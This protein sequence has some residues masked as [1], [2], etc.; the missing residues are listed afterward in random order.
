VRDPV[1]RNIS[2]FFES[3]AEFI[4]DFRPESPSG[5]PRVEELI[6]TFLDRYDHD[7]PLLWF[8]H[9]MKPVFGIDVFARAFPKERGYG[10][11]EGPNASLLVIKLEKVKECVEGAMRDF[12]GLEEFVLRSANVAD[13]KGY[14]AVY[15]MFLDAIELPSAY[16]DRMY[17]SQLARHFYTEEE[18]GAFR[19]RW[20]KLPVPVNGPLESTRAKRVES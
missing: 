18:I 9:Q 10:V 17:E 15:R 4:P 11:Y 7:T 20:L 1:A 5:V 8:D 19:R 13:H 16:L 12:L 14:G 3:I 2:A 6:A